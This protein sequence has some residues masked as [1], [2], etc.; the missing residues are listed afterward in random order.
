[1][2]TAE[3]TITGGRLPLKENGRTIF[4][5]LDEV[6]FFEAAR[7]YVQVHAGTGQYRVRETLSTFAARLPASNFLRI[8]RSIIVN[9]DRV[10]EVQPWFKGDYVL[11]L[12]DGTKLRSGRTYRD[13]VQ[14][15]VR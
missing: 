12:R 1:M 6:E 4:V 15:L 9:A 13:R 14:A 3:V 8:H 10:K 7:N 5:P 2:S 11:V